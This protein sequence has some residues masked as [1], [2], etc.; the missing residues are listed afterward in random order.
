MK[1]ARG[2]H[3]TRNQ[4]DVTA[5][6][7]EESF[8]GIIPDS[9]WVVDVLF[10]Q[11]KTNIGR[12]ILPFLGFFWVPNAESEPPCDTDDGVSNQVGRS[13]RVARQLGRL[14]LR[15]DGRKIARLP[16]NGTAVLLFHSVATTKDN[17]LGALEL[18]HHHLI[19]FDRFKILHEKRGRG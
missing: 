5:D 19:R 2:L 15:V 4:S 17:G 3:A 18:A 12:V 13:K 7:L 14:D 16:P 8:N 6:K 9:V 11:I 1:M 10:G